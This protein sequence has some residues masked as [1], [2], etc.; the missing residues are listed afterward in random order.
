MS[1]YS[2]HWV[3]LQ[4]SNIR[5]NAELMRRYDLNVPAY[6]SYPTPPHFHADFDVL[7]YR[8]AALLSNA[9]LDAFEA[10]IRIPP[11][12]G[13][14]QSRYLQC[15]QREIELQSELFDPRRA[16]TQLAIS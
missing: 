12:L 1:L 4:M 2:R 14:A 6:R 8:R 7:A 3:A 9:T 16:I 11:Q 15:L 10:E 13:A 5:S